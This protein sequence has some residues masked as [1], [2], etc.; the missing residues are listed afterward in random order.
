[1]GIL[2]W[3]HW[4]GW[5]HTYLFHTCTHM[6]SQVCL[7]KCEYTEAHSRHKHMKTYLCFPVSRRWLISTPQSF[8]RDFRSG[9][10]FFLFFYK[11]TQSKTRRKQA[12]N[13]IKAGFDE[14]HGLELFRAQL[15]AWRMLSISTDAA[16][17]PMWFFLYFHMKH[18]GIIL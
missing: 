2:S 11:Y 3:D 6:C 16:P 17:C 13:V 5:R 14:G 15:L 12:R 10:L 4:I 18:L 7:H 8:K 9:F 1:M